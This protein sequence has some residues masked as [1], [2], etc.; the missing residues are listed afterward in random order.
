MSCIYLTGVETWEAHGLF[1]YFLSEPHK[2]MLNN[3]YIANNYEKIMNKSGKQLTFQ[4]MCQLRICR[5]E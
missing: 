3:E 2:L 4:R 5:F 1:Y